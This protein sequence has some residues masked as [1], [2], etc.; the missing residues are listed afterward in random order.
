MSW[1]KDWVN[2]LFVFNEENEEEEAKKIVV[3]PP[4]TPSECERTTARH[5][6]YGLDDDDDDDDDG[7]NENEN[8]E[9]KNDVTIR[10]E[11][12][13]T[14]FSPI[15]L[16]SVEDEVYSCEEKATDL[17]LGREPSEYWFQHHDNA[18]KVLTSHF[19]KETRREALEKEK[20]RKR[21]QE[22][23]IKNNNKYLY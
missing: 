7:E 13:S 10:E 17:N 15:N 18:D 11:L 5:P 12:Q 4:I 14:P 19:W 6:R 2:Y 22:K 16:F 1:L 21:E 9:G 8:E 23:V 20:E 3:P